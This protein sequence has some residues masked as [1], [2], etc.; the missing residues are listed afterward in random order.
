MRSIV[1]AAVLALGLEAGLAAQA[2]SPATPPAPAASDAPSQPAQGQSGTPTST[3]Q[4]PGQPAP[5]NAP[6]ENDKKSLKQK[7]KDQFGTGCTSFGPCWGKEKPAEDRSAP[8]FPTPAAN[9]TAPRSDS[10][11][12]SKDTKVDLAPPPGELMGRPATSSAAKGASD[13]HEMRPWDPHKA[14]KNIEVG[15]YY[16][17]QKNYRAAIS[18]YQEALK[19]EDNNAIAMYRLGQALEAVGKYQEARERYAGY[20]KILPEGKY[21]TEAQN[22]VDRLEKKSDDAR[23]SDGPIL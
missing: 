10:E 2:Q 7:L 11:S 18:R 15:D 23:K 6:D 21:A 9:Q 1:L 16:M 22:K 12:S 20:L 13:V 4:T 19:W 17:H 3:A 8:E 14:D 5:P